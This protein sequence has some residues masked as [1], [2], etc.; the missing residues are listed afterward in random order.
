MDR[1]DKR[2]CINC[3]G[4]FEY[5]GPDPDSWSLFF[6]PK[7]GKQLTNKEMNNHWMSWVK[8]KIGKSWSERVVRGQR[9]EDDWPEG[10]PAAKYPPE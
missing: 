7:C 4:E 9:V 2:L 10:F 3:G 8:A 5:R 6:C 1:T